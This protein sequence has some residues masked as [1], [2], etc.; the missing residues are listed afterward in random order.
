MVIASRI[1]G[2][3]RYNQTN[4]KR[5]VFQSLNHASDF[6]LKTITC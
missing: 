3:S 6:R 4:S 5:S 2:Y 1:D